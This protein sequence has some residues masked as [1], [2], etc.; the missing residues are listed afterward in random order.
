MLDRTL[1]RLL[2]ER[3][4]MQK[5]YPAVPMEAIGKTTRVI[6]KQ[7][8]DWLEENPDAG[9]VQ[10]DEFNTYFALRNPKLSPE[11]LKAFRVE[12]ADIGKPVDDTV[13]R[14]IRNRLAEARTSAMLLELL[15]GYE[16]GE[17]DLTAGLRGI[18][19][20]HESQTKTSKEATTIAVDITDELDKAESDWGFKFRL[21]ILNE[22]VRPL[23][24]GDFVIVGAR[25]GVGK[26]SF[27]ASELTF[28]A[29]QVD[30]LYPDENRTILIL[31]N[32]GPGRRIRLRTYCSAI[33]TDTAGLG[34]LRDEGKNLLELYS[35]AQGGRNVIQIEDIHG[36]GTYEVEQLIVKHNPA[37][38]LIDMLDN[39]QFDGTT[40]NNGERGDQILGALYSLARIWGVKYDTVVFAMSQ[41]NAKAVGERFP[42]LDTLANST[43]DKPGTADLI[44]TIAEDEQDHMMRS[45][46]IG[47]PKN[48]LIRAHGRECPRAEVR[49]DN[50]TGRYTDP[51]AK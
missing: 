23:Q 28:M 12:F 14:G 24:G 48:K 29:K 50:R 19:E 33:G 36:M 1:L 32:E 35:K 3:E 25:V 39:V 10:P 47:C 13:T 27:N 8:R 41:L 46:F 38:L 15:D 18:A 34:K 37:I 31:N 16:N 40:N 22:Y 11:Q 49:F 44:I 42:G 30:T 20:F 21:N 9:R 4:P 45:R 5:L 7:M 26:T 17:T 43:T 2:S 6:L 51:V